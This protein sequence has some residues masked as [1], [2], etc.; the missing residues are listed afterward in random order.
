M[1]APRPAGSP[2]GAFCLQLSF[3]HP[4]FPMSQNY[5]SLLILSIHPFHI[6][7]LPSPTVSFLS[8][9]PASFLTL[10]SLSSSL[11]SL[12]LCCT[13]V[14]YFLPILLSFL[15]YIHDSILLTP[16]VSC[17]STLSQQDYSFLSYHFLFYLPSLSS[18]CVRASALPSHSFPF[19]SASLLSH[20]FHVSSFSQPFSWFSFCGTSASALS[21]PSSLFILHSLLPSST[22]SIP[23]F[24]LLPSLAPPSHLF[25]P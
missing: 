3:T 5:H 1:R 13:L 17:H 21:L 12:S 16:A 20:F 6:F 9:I 4:S 22:F 18:G 11:F 8:S 25:L 23:H 7:T 2:Q 10:V 24:K 14:P 19:C 15:I